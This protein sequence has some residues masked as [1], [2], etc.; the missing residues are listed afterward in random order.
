M[1]THA[2][3][4]DA[5]LADLKADAWMER[6]QEI[7]TAIGE[8]KKLGPNHNA[9]LLDAGP[10][11]LVSFEDANALR[12][13]AKGGEPRSFAHTRRDGW[14]TLTILCSRATWFRDEAVYEYFDQLIDDGFFDEYEQVLFYGQGP[15]GYAAAAFSV[16]APGARVLALS[17]MATMNSRLAAFDPRSRALKRVDFTSRYGY[18]PDMIEAADHAYIIHDV[19]RRIDCIHA[20]MFVRKNVTL[21]RTFGIGVHLDQAF[22]DFDILEDLFH[23]AMAGSLTTAIFADQLRARRENAAYLCW[24]IERAKEMGHP[25]LAKMASAVAVKLV[26][27]DDLISLHNVIGK[28]QNAPSTEAAE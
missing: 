22:E 25:K 14:S 3:S 19:N 23:A 26:D 28:Q 20:G 8:F 17:P 5:G 1:T 16:A 21:L 18:A 12:Q 2:I 11:L 4:F 15:C 13:T 27:G 24:I 6:V 9:V 7:G 10:K